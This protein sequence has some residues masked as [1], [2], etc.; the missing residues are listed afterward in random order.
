M[1]TER[2]V[3]ADSSIVG[4]L[5]VPTSAKRLIVVCH[6]Y[7]SSKES[8]TLVA[9]ARR[10]HT[11]GYA[12]FA[13]DFSPTE[14]GIGIAQQTQDLEAI[15]EHFA[16]FKDIIL[17][18]LSFS[19]I[20]A[21]IASTHTSRVSGLVTVGGFFGRAALGREYRRTYLLFRA[22]TLVHPTS[23]ALARYLKKEL[24]PERITSPVLVIHS[25]VDKS[26]YISQSRWFYAKLTAPKQFVELETASHGLADD[27]DRKLVVD[28]IHAWLNDPTKR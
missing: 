22:T 15:V 17:L 28:A 6:G 21:S 14:D 27:K 3:I 4:Q 8:P 7:H 18:A 24:R 25:K 12:T 11:L 26:V 23:R 9:I 16:G 13:F 5:T 2:V 20:S 1:K 10:L 19:A